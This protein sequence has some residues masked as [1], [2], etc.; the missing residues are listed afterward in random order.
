MPKVDIPCV[1]GPLNG[2]LM[3]VDVDDDGYPPAIVSETDLFV[4]YGG[5][6]LDADTSG[7]YEIESVGPP[8][9]RPWHYIWVPRG[10]FT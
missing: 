10:A 8:G 6:L 1:G 9:T 4:A 7:H 5:E 2:R 3:E